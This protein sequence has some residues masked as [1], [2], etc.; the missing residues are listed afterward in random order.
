M[1][2]SSNSRYSEAEISY[3]LS[4]VCIEADHIYRVAIALTGDESAAFRHLKSG[5]T[6]MVGELRVRASS[7][8]DDNRAEILRHVWAD[9]GSSSPASLKTGAVSE[10]LNG[11]DA[12]HRGI[13]VASDVGG[14]SPSELAHAFKLDETQ[15]RKL[16]A[17]SRRALC[18]N[19]TPKSA[20]VD[21]FLS[22]IGDFLEESSVTEVSRRI[23][24]LL[25]KPEFLE[26]SESFQAGQG[27]LQVTMQSFF[28]GSE[29]M[30]EIYE[31][32]EAQDIRQTQELARIEATERSEFAS[33]VRKRIT[34]LLGLSIAIFSVV[35][36][37]T[38]PKKTEVFDP[39]RYLSLETIALIEDPSGRLDYVLRPEAS[40][41]PDDEDAEVAVEAPVAVA[42]E[43]PVTDAAVELQEYFDKHP[44]LDFKPKVLKL[45]SKAW[46]P[47][48]GSVFDYD[49]IR[50]AVVQYRSQDSLQESVVHFSY[51]GQIADLPPSESGEFKQ[52]SVALRYQAYGSDNLNIVAWQELDGV[53][54]MMIGTRGV[55]DLA[56]IVAL[57]RN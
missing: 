56:R 36:Y 19:K 49:D 27:Q 10:Y 50:V 34:I 40:T 11:L 16:I 42:S 7:D 12:L 47:V 24:E 37:S 44:E 25:K 46:E 4:K 14:L 48:G 31:L 41:A 23:D 5:M 33:S 30:Q 52:D 9:A 1:G 2:G 22:H 35:Y 20:D 55:V 17:E 43:A 15:I 54:G 28:V 32:V 57:A 6:R 26:L 39:I 29:R 45:D 51:R 38:S 8:R 21:Y 53:V 18:G 13:L 3:F